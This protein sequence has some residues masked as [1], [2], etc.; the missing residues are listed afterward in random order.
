MW[1]PPVRTRWG[2]TCCHPQPQCFLWM[3]VLIYVREANRMEASLGSRLHTSALWAWLFWPSGAT[4]AQ[5]STCTILFARLAY[6]QWKS[7][8]VGLLLTTFSYESINL[9]WHQ[10]ASPTAG[11]RSKRVQRTSTSLLPWTSSVQS[12][13]CYCQQLHARL[14]LEIGEDCVHQL[15]N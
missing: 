14:L 5:P 8:V 11:L 6:R 12:L 9:A 13:S 10:W 4:T 3:V 1:V 15:T 2:K 7:L